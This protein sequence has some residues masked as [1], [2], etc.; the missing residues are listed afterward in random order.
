MRPAVPGSAP[1]GKRL[2]LV[3][4]RS[5]VAVHL[6]DKGPLLGRCLEEATQGCLTGG[7][8][9]HDQA[10]GEHVLEVVAAARR[11]ASAGQ[12]EDSSGVRPFGNPAQERRLGPAESLLAF[13]AEYL[14]DTAA[15]SGLYSLVE[16]LETETFDSQTSG[17]RGKSPP[18]SGL[19]A[20]RK[21][22]EIYGPCAHF[23]PS[24]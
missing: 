2:Y 21:A 12:D 3:A 23:F 9:F 13:G 19:P 16:I 8:Q 10:S 24:A 6:S 18:E 4:E 7:P 5:G 15:F 20:G 14:G 11:A 22:Y 17:G 1:R